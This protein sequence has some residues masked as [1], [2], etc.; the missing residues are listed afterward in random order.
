MHPSNRPG[1][2]LLT[3]ASVAVTSGLMLLA[4]QAAA[5]EP[6]AA[7]A[8]TTL[9]QV[10][11]SLDGKPQPVLY[12]APESAATQAAPLLV[13]LH[14]WSGDYRQS[15]Q[16]WLNQAA[17][18]GWIY[19]HPN[20]RGRN[21]DPE[22]C[23]SALARQDILDAIDVICEKYQVDRERIYLAGSSGGGHM[24]MLM[25]GYHPDRFSAVSAWVGI[26]DLAAWRRHH[27]KNGEPQN[28]ARMVDASCGGA[29]G[30]SPEVDAQYRARSPLFHLQETGDLLLDL[31]A[32]VN[33][34]HTGSVPIRHTLDAFNVVAKAGKQETISEDEIQQLTQDRKLKEPR[35][36]D[37]GFDEAYNR[38]FLLRR[39]AGPARV[40]IFD[41]GHE[42][43]PNAGC[44]WL[45]RQQRPTKK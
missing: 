10:T 13:Y 40:T 26:S 15:N 35:A 27:T 37:Q 24:S 44:S 45:S 7:P 18:R 29:P 1:R 11:S 38:D 42:G 30:A 39:Q 32:G 28:Y 23:G 5:E 4:G 36:T 6:A 14:S 25:A 3:A 22:A 12:W 20:F 34:G 41:G 2:K 9:L 21:D 43:L 19:L 16:A 17:Q 8:K 33:D 31:N